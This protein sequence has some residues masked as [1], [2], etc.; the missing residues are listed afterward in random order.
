MFGGLLQR[1]VCDQYGLAWSSA[2]NTSN[3]G[4]GLPRSVIRKKHH[5]GLDL[6]E[7]NRWIDSRTRAIALSSTLASTGF[8]NDLVVLGERC[9][10]TRSS[11]WWMQ[12][13]YILDFLD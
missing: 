10:H 12:P 7:L 6:G 5:G 2:S 9:R 3:V 1:R 13:M 11:W 8:R 4:A